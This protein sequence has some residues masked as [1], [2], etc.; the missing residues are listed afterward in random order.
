MNINN[1]NMSAVMHVPFLIRL[2]MLTVFMCSSFTE[3]LG[4]NFFTVQVN[5][6]A[7]GTRTRTAIQVLDRHD[8]SYL[9]RYKLMQGYHSV[10]INVLYN[11]Q[12]IAKSPY[13]LSG[14]FFNYLCHSCCR[15]LC[16]DLHFCVFF[17]FVLIMSFKQLILN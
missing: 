12:H 3:S 7:D 14:I 11:G 5:Q 4:S 8:G 6:A 9:V 17:V 2:F 15:V 10:V 16:A 13:T 1:L